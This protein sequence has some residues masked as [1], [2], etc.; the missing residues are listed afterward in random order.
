MLSHIVAID[1]TG[2]I[3]KDHELPWDL[4][5]DR[6]R[7]WRRT[8]ELGEAILI[9]RSTR[10][11]I[12]RTKLPLPTY[13]WVRHASPEDYKRLADNEKF[14]FNL[15][16]FLQTHLDTN[17]V[18]LGGSTLYKRTLALGLVSL[19]DL[20]YID[21]DFGTDRDTRYPLHPLKRNAYFGT[22]TLLEKHKENNY[23]IT[24]Y[25]YDASQK[26]Y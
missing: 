4:P 24:Q 20:T 26:A 15:E 13:I 14:V 23:K 21:Y 19:V 5:E 8:L 17:F 10:E 25:L 18:A 9:S 3:S 6:A 12:P 1:R 2:G 7:M 16:K 22:P 11:Q